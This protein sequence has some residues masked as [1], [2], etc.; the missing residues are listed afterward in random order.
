MHGY[1]FSGQTP[2][3]DGVKDFAITYPV[4]D[5][6]Q[7]TVWKKYGITSHPS[8]ALIASDGTVLDRQVGGITAPAATQ[9][10]NATANGGK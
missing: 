4:V 10:I 9:K 1:D 8:W 2:I 5:D 6:T 3:A 7:K